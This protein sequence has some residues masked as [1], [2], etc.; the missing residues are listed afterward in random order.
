MAVCMAAVVLCTATGLYKVGCVYC[1]N[2]ARTL[3]VF[4]AVYLPL[5][6]TFLPSLSLLPRLTGIGEAFSGVPPVGA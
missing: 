5:I 4:A 2:P 3:R 1:A 6:C